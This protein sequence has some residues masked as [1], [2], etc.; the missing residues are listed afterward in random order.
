M[1]RSV[2]D[3]EVEQQDRAQF[4]GC[5]VPY[6]EVVLKHPFECSRKGAPKMK[7]KNMDD[8][9]SWGPGGF[10]VRPCVRNCLGRLDKRYG[11]G[12]TRLH[13]AHLFL[14]NLPVVVTVQQYLG[15]YV[16]DAG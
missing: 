1:P 14:P 10:D 4:R 7:S 12:M 9:L 15:I 11:S 8:T 3:V 2:R 5:N 13:Y 6:P 16:I